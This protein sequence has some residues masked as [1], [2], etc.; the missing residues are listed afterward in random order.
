MQNLNLHSIL[1]IPFFHIE[2]TS[3]V[4]PLIFSILPIDNPL[5][6]P[7]N[8]Q[9]NW[10]LTEFLSNIQRCKKISPHTLDCFHWIECMF[11][12]S[13][14]LTKKMHIYLVGVSRWKSEIQSPWLVLL[15]IVLILRFSSMWGRWIRSLFVD[16]LIRA[17]HSS[18][19]FF[20]WRTFFKSYSF[21]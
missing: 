19:M 13:H 3:H 5:E 15:V 16:I 10:I 2:H 1:A 4:I 21:W 9:L 14:S 20:I 18:W 6:Q 11:W 7:W 17:L 12:M 8:L